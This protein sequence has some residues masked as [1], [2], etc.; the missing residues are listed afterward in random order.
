[1][2]VFFRLEKTFFIYILI[3]IANGRTMIVVSKFSQLSKDKLHVDQA[4]SEAEKSI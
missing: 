3:I 4:V 1:M 2:F